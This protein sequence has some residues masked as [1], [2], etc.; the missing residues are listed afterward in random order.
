MRLNEALLKLPVEFSP[1]DLAA[2]VNA[3]PASAWVPHPEK[4]PGN[5]AVPLISPG[6]A[7]T[8]AI[9]GRMAPTEF[10]R[11][12][13]YIQGILA[14]LGGPW[15]RSRLMGLGAGADVPNHVDINYY[16]RTHLR[17][18]IPVV[19][20]PGV[21]FHCGG[22]TVHMKP[23][24]CWT[25]DS[26]RQHRVEN[27]G[28]ERRIHL[29]I[30]TVG[31]ERLFDLLEAARQKVPVRR[32]AKAEVAGAAPEFERFNAP[33][34]MSPWEVRSHVAY[35][36]DHVVPHPALERV[37]QALDRFATA[38]S[39]LWAQ[40]ADTDKGTANYLR[41]IGQTRDELHAIPGGDEIVLQNGWALYQVLDR[42]V[43]LNAV[44]GIKPQQLPSG[45]QGAAG[46]A[47]GA[48]ASVASAA[49]AR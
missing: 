4:F 16:W 32:L 24:E 13:P 9:S 36:A 30:D 49:R 41:R 39:G 31:S 14:A 42:L 47:G 43:F 8:N 6:G 10:L 27:R 45:A 21:L 5:D 20:N 44:A 18:H 33:K 7:I 34:V 23:G 3:L 1:D 29:V 25:F 37:M 40:F 28:T 38:W 46:R 11:R 15:G 26:F 19:T 2:E 17:I 12:C 48:Y 35:L 22:E